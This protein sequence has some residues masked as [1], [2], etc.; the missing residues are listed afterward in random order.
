MK[1]KNEK[2]SSK[3]ASGYLSAK[4]DLFRRTFAHLE[5]R[6]NSKPLRVLYLLAVASLAILG[7]NY[8]P[9]LFLVT[10]AEQWT[11]DIVY[12]ALFVYAC[13]Q[14][15]QM[16]RTTP[17]F[18]LLGKIGKQSTIMWFVHGMFFNICKDKLQ[19]L[20][21]WPRNPL[22]VLLNGLLICYLAACLL[23]VPI[24]FLQNL[25]KK[26]GQLL[27]MPFSKSKNAC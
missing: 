18:S 7:R 5:P 14:Q 21:Y 3:C 23:S 4:Y 20:L 16:C 9:I 10:L 1:T 2:Y 19:M 24:G 25:R 27:L 26:L 15:L 22:L 6:G 8:A 11:M 13:D 17:L 12:A